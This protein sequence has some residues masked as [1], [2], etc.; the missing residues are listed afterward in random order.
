MAPLRTSSLAND[1]DSRLAATLDFVFLSS[2]Y[3]AER[4]PKYETGDRRR[5][6]ATSRDGTAILAGKVAITVTE[7]RILYSD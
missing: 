6:N 3:T 2:T 5:I 1:G 4:A 7:R